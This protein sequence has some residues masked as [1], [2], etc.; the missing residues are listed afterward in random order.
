MQPE[1]VVAFQLSTHHSRCVLWVC[2]LRFTTIGCLQVTQSAGL[3]GGR[4]HAY[5]ALA[6]APSLV[7]RGSHLVFNAQP[8]TRNPGEGMCCNQFCKDWHQF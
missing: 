4:T 6:Q 5:N 7:T 1:L 2:L 3:A 8:L